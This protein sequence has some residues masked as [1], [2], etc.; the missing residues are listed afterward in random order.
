MADKVELM[1]K[2]ADML[3]TLNDDEWFPNIGETNYFKFPDDIA[4]V[5][6]DQVEIEDANVFLEKYD[7][8]NTY[9]LKE[10]KGVSFENSDAM[11]EVLNE[12]GGMYEFKFGFDLSKAVKKSNEPLKP[13]EWTR[14]INVDY[15]QFGAGEIVGYKVAISSDIDLSSL[16]SWINE[17][18]NLQLKVS[19]LD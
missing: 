11:I 7:E 13:G 8:L 3:L 15:L 12:E 2:M 18:T 9:V 6:A 4:R 17:V 14:E 1:K 5:G 16:E 10:Y 19:L